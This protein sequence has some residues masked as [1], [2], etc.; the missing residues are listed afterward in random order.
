MTKT[1]VK[2]TEPQRQIVVGANEKVCLNCAHYDPWLCRG[3]SNIVF[4]YITSR[5]RC[6]KHSKDKSALQRPCKDFEWEEHT[7]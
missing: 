1:D 6:V 5:G 4:Y 3:Y 7:K 2:P